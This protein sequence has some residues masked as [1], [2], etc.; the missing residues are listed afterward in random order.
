MGRPVAACNDL[1]EMVE[2]VLILSVLF[3]TLHWW[4]A[5]VNLHQIVEHH[6]ALCATIACIPRPNI[7]WVSL[8][9]SVFC[10]CKWHNVHLC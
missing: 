3:V 2:F 7:V 10:H 8:T 9:S 4:K 1:Q 5:A 6:F